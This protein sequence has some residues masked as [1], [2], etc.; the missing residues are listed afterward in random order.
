LARLPI[1]FPVG[2]DL[3]CRVPATSAGQVLPYDDAA[4]DQWVYR[5]YRLT[6]VEIAEVEAHFADLNRRAA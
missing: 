6:K 1:V 4:I 2:Q 3:S 5:L